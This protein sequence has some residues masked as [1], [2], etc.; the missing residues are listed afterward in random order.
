LP[1]HVK[2][3]R[4]PALFQEL[5][6]QLPELLVEQVVGL[7]DQ[8]DQGVGGN[9]G[10]RG[11]DIGL[12]GQIGPILGVGQLPDG[13]RLGVVLAPQR[14]TAL[15]QEILKIQQQL[16]QAGPG[17][18]DQLQL[19]FFRG[20]RGHAAFGDVLLAA[21]GRLHHLVVG[22]GAGVDEPVT[23][24]RGGVIDNFRHLVGL[25]LAESAVGVNEAIR[26]A[27]ISHLFFSIGRKQLISPNPRSSGQSGRPARR[28]LQRQQN[29]LR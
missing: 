15:T 27:H 16:L 26:G 12:I 17:H 7:V 25:Q 20:A 19:G 14:Q 23:E 3:L 1:C 6:L 24:S 29:P 10:E 13:L 22:A 21:S 8:A 2:L 18:S 4:E 28:P 5:L 11:F 9:L